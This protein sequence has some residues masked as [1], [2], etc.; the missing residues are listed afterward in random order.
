MSVFKAGLEMLEAESMFIDALKSVKLVN[1][2][3][4][5]SSLSLVENRLNDHGGFCYYLTALVLMA[6]S[7][8]HRICGTIDTMPRQ[9]FRQTKDYKH[10]WVEFEYGENW[11]VYDSLYEHIIPREEWYEMCNPRQI[12]SDLTLEQVMKKY[13]RKQYACKIAENIW[14]F[15]SEKDIPER[16]R[17]ADKGD[18][19]FFNSIQKGYL[20]FNYYDFD[21]SYFTKTF[22]AYDGRYY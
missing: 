20:M 2:N 18:G 12:I 5:M 9:G 8:G 6:L 17:E 4:A 11:Y 13:L 1:K 19:F 14:V 15:K 22:I 16:C 3:G 7:E 21:N 10:A